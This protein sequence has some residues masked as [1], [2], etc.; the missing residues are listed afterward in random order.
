MPESVKSRAG[1]KVTW[2]Y[3]SDKAIAEEASKV[4]MHNAAIDASLGYDFGYCAPGSIRLIGNEWPEYQ[5]LY[6][7]CTS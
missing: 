5:G 6:E 2:Q 1:C 4:A 7:V 3:Y